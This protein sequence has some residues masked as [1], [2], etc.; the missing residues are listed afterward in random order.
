M[1]SQENMAGL[2]MY[3]NV[4]GE[5]ALENLSRNFSSETDRNYYQGRVDQVAQIRKY[6]NYSQMLI[7]N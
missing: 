5:L 3:L 7:S 2:E 6:L 4:Q 1:L